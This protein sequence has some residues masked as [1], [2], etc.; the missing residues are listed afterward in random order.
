MNKKKQLI[1]ERKIFNLIRSSNRA[2]SHLNYFRAYMSEN[3]SHIDKK[4]NLWKKLRKLDYNCYTEAILKNGNRLDIL[5]VKEGIGIA[6]EILESETKEECMEK[7]KDLPEGIEIVLIKT[8][9]DLKKW[10]STM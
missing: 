9:E 4:F 6:F 1:E 10:I 3:E 5:A 7:L 8:D 2:G